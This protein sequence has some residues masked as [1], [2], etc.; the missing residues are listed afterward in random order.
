MSLIALGLLAFPW[1]MMPRRKAGEIHGLTVLLWWLNAIYCGFWHRLAV[2]GRDPLPAEGACILICNHTCCIDH[3]LLQAA[4]G[5]LLGFIIAKEIHEI[6]WFKP[7]CQLSGCIPVNR[8]G[9]DLVAMRAALRALHAGR[10]LPI[11]PEGTITPASG[12]VLG[13]AKPGVA[14]IALKA[15]VPVIPAYI[16]GTPASKEIGP[17]LWTPSRAELYFGPPV[18]LED[19]REKDGSSRE[20]LDEVC[21]RLMG[22]IRLLRDHAQGALGPLETD[23]GH[24]GR[25]D[26]SALVLSGDRSTA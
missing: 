16:R 9:K 19:L 20:D 24:D 23:H 15:R 14:F 25:A 3:M 11:F 21:R 6:W 1:V 8:D 26:D 17:S 22:S 12:R 10:V 4:T 18:D 7:F 2:K 13:E 5:R